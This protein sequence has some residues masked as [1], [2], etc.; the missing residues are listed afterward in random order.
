M[1][2]N[3]NDSIYQYIRVIAH[4]IS[5]ETATGGTTTYSEVAVLSRFNTLTGSVT[6]LCTD[7][8]CRH[9]EEDNCPFANVTSIHFYHGIVYYLR[10]YFDSTQSPAVHTFV[11]CSYD[12]VNAKVKVLYEFESSGYNFRENIFVISQRDAE[13]KI[14]YIT[15]DLESGKVETLPDG[16]EPPCFVYDNRFYYY[17]SAEN[18]FLTAFYSTDADG[19]HKQVY[20][21]ADCIAI[22]FTDSFDGRFFIWGEY[23]K[24]ELNGK[25]V[26][27]T[28]HVILHRY[29]MKLDEDKI[30]NHD[31]S[32]S[33]CAQ[34]DGKLYYAKIVDNPPYLGSDLNQSN[35]AD[36]YNMSGGIIWE[37]DPESGEERVFLELPDYTLGRTSIE[38]VGDLIV[39]DYTNVD[40]SQ[41]L[42]SDGDGWYDYPTE[43]GKIVFNPATAE[44]VIYT[45]PEFY[46]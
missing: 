41:P 17:E 46:Q 18:G 36:R 25:Q 31:F 13:G 8:I 30:V 11:L 33:Y 22:V 14:R 43:Y 45:L 26:L 7:P 20:F 15:V 10:S 38:R 2:S 16:V 40:Y 6:S 39:I 9:V 24:K 5:V 35:N 19:N 4:N 21:T 34:Y 32:D 28:D 29:D 1:N 42:D 23:G 37:L 12:P 27:D 44:Y 3:I